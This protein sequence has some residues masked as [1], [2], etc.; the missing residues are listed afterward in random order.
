MII[1]GAV[2]VF[3]K[4]IP[5]ASSEIALFMSLI[6]SVFLSTIVI[7][8]KRS[9][10]WEPIK[11]NLAGL[12]FSSIALSGNWIFLFQA[13]KETTIANA[14]LSYYFAPVL[15][16]V[17]SPIVLKESLSFKKVICVGTAFLGLMGIVLGGGNHHLLGIFY[18]LVAAAFYA[19][20]TLSNKFIRNVS[21]LENTLVQLLLSAALL[22]PYV[23]MMAGRISDLRT[24]YG[25]HYGIRGTTYRN[26]LL[27]VLF[28]H[29]GI[30]RS[31]YRG[32]KLSRSPDFRIDFHHDFWRKDDDTSTRWCPIITRINVSQ[33][34]A[35]ICS[36]TE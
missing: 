17:V 25:P 1:F 20:L 11:Q 36:R 6:G 28:R 21:S 15:V 3:A 29:E 34:N 23:F 13:Y 26:R 22:V 19:T 30:K 18:G 24:F 10:P 12:L 14:A 32:I 5:L 8:S 16:I 31:K 7:A 27:S 4:L 9:I 2:G 35:N 33:R